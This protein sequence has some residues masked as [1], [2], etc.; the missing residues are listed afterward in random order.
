ME[1]ESPR[2][3]PLA[4]APASPRQ[5]GIL[6]GVMP[7]AVLWLFCLFAM[8]ACA[9]WLAPHDPTEQFREHLLLPPAWSGGT[10]AFPFG[11]D[12]LGRDMLSRLLHGARLSLMIG[13]AANIAALVPGV[14]LGLF[15]ASH[16]RCFGFFTMRLMDALLALPSLLLAVAVVAVLGAGLVNTILAIALVQLPGVVRLTRAA[17]LDELGRDYVTASRMAGAG[18]IRLLFAAVLPNCLPP[19]IVQATLGF[20]VA[21]LDVAAL[22]FLGLGAPPPTPEWGAMLASAR[23]FIET[24][25]WV[26][27]LPGMAIMS[28]VLAI[29]LFGD[30]LRDWLDPK[31]RMAM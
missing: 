5:G 14:I 19:L 30:G 17:A 23:D 21:I 31:L 18:T 29:N 16:P 20:S 4:R 9:P 11:T 7:L 28:A 25:P 22:G 8:A 27:Y 24:A 12:D 2:G 6:N 15:A 1:P 13:L 26:V 3:V 10:L